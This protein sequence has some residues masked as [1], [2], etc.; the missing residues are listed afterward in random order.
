M[1]SIKEQMSKALLGELES[2]SLVKD[3]VKTYRDIDID[4]GD[5]KTIMFL[6]S[7]NEILLSMLSLYQFGITRKIADI[8]NKIKGNKDV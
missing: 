3:F 8:K 2:P 6:A 4:I 7:N 5:E 1:A